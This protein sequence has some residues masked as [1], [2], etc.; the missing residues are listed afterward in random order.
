MHETVQHLAK[1][2]RILGCHCYEEVFMWRRLRASGGN[3]TE[4]WNCA[5]KLIL[6]EKCHNLLL[7]IQ[8]KDM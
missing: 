4:S 7:K 3:I 2:C 1:K 8:E 5:Y 6:T